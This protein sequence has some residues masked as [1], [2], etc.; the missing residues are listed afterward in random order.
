MQ[1]DIG[2]NGVA[3]VTFADGV[4]AVGGPGKAKPIIFT[5]GTGGYPSPSASPEQATCTPDGGDLSL[6]ASSI[7]FDTDCLAAPAD[8]AFT[9]AFDNQDASVPHNVAIYPEG[10]GAK[11]VF[12]GDLV[13]GVADTTYQVPALDAG[14]YRFQCD[15]HPTMNGTFIVG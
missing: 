1:S 9:I 14:T 11:A 15:V 3:T 8:T 4:Y 2:V 10:D 12:T 6:T 13:T 5:V 7:A